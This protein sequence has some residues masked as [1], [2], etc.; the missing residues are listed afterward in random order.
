[1]ACHVTANCSPQTTSNKGRGKD[2]KFNRVGDRGQGASRHGKELDFV[3]GAPFVSVGFFFR[4]DAEGSN[5]EDHAT[6][7][8]CR[9]ARRV[10]IQ[11]HTVPRL[12]RTALSGTVKA[13]V[14][15]CMHLLSVHVNT[16]M[17][18]IFPNRSAYYT[19]C[20]VKNT[21]L[22]GVRLLVFLFCLEPRGV[23]CVILS[24]Y[25]K[26]RVSHLREKLTNHISTFF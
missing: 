12:E 20:W 25:E 19:R 9:M 7:Y 13:S 15:N 22:P 16:Q 2:S 18:I 10:I 14:W 11:I 4:S 17:I 24:R 3:H 21:Y 26:I 1:M 5:V 23:Q 8:Y 6:H